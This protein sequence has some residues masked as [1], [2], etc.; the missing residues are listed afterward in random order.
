MKRQQVKHIDDLERSNKI[1]SALIILVL[2]V[3]VLILVTMLFSNT[4]LKKEAVKPKVIEPLDKECQIKISTY[5]EKEKVD[6]WQPLGIKC[7][8]KDDCENDIKEKGAT[9]WELFLDNV[10][11]E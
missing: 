3:I 7:N 1:W 4:I 9:D 11:C 6:I 2:I 8:T 10:R 5:V